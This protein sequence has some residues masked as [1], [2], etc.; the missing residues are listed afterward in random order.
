MATAIMLISRQERWQT[1]D[2]DVCPVVEPRCEEERSPLQMLAPLACV[3]GTPRGVP[4]PV[5]SA[6]SAPSP[7]YV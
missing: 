2:E 1:D 3:R 6:T 4:L 5:R 7:R